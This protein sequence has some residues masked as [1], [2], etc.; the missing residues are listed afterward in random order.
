VLSQRPGR[1]T[2]AF[3]CLQLNCVRVGACP[4]VPS[5]GWRGP[6]DPRPLRAAWPRDSW[7]GDRR[8]R[9]GWTTV[10]VGDA[11]GQRPLRW[12]ARRPRPTSR[13]S[14][15]IHSHRGA[16]APAENPFETVTPARS[17]SRPGGNLGG[18]L[19]APA[20]R[21]VRNVYHR[22]VPLLAGACSSRGLGDSASRRFVPGGSLVGPGLPFL[23]HVA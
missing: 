20:Q 1:M 4:D 3:L 6:R 12:T 10:V 7:S 22:G 23:A 16:T 14:L 11:R 2:T 5:E 9:R 17:T 18:D 21:R 13:R 19:D 8:P 15:G